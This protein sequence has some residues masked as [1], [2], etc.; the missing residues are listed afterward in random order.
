M[1]CFYFPTVLHSMALVNG[2]ELTCSISWFY[3]GCQ[4]IERTAN[5][6]ARPQRNFNGT[7][8]QQVSYIF[9]GSSCKVL[10]ANTWQTLLWLPFSRSYDTDFI[11]VLMLHA[12]DIEHYLING[13]LVRYSL[14]LPCILKICLKFWSFYFPVLFFHLYTLLS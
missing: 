3:T 12:W 1:S 9:T 11:S 13:R 10:R 8:T 14:F 2:T 7:W 6:N 5:G 4:A